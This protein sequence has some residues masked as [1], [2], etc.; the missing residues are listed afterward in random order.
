MN[1]TG[2]GAWPKYGRGGTLNTKGTEIGPYYTL[3][4]EPINQ[5]GL[6]AWCKGMQGEIVSLD[7]FA[8]HQGVFAIQILS[9]SYL[10]NPKLENADGI[11]GPDTLRL[12]KDVQRKA[13]LIVDGVVGQK[14]MQ[15]LLIPVIQQV[16]DEKKVPFNAIYGL[17]H[18]E[19]NWDPGAVGVLDP[20]D[21]GLAQINTK[22]HPHVAP[23][24]AFC[25][26]FAVSF[27]ADYL[28]TALDQLG[29]LQ[30]A[31]IS[32]NLGIGGT[33]QWIAA[34]R[35]EVWVPKWSTL[36][37]KP[38]DYYNNIIGVWRGQPNT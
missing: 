4:K 29:N 13:G 3:A 23:S 17:L 34:G 7:Y 10:G 36:P 9:N 18:F 19:G 24:S 12:V 30:D 21:L 5:I 37:R 28:R 32:Y 11:F 2:R 20:E 31:V 35:P 6:Y 26:S 1:T 14:T 38:F 33:R 27:I 25:P 22:A 15:A 16:S 8:T